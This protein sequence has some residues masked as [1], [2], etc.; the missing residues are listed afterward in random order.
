MISSRGIERGRCH[1]SF[2]L[3]DLIVICES[4][5]C[6][7]LVSTRVWETNRDC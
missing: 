2:C 5:E 6:L 1:A 4:A 7:K 3:N